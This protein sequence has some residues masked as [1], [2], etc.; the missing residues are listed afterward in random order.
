MEQKVEKLYQSIKAINSAAPEKLFDIVVEEASKILDVEL[1]SLLLFD[2]DKKHLRIKSAKGL[3]QTIIKNTVI[4]KGDGIVGKVAETGEPLLIENIQDY[5]AFA[6]K[7][8][9]T[10]YKTQSLL[11]VPIKLKNEII[12][13]L[14]VNNKVA[15]ESFNKK[16]LH[17]LSIF[18]S[19]ISH[20][21]ISKPK[22]SSD[23]RLFSR[24]AST[25]ETP[26]F[27]A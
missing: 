11:T 22:F 24:K 3:Y 16:D 10:K 26:E 25:S 1:C 27:L 4:N 7:E 17:I 8:L 19:Q 20:Y 12:G 21:L 15:G 6:K 13:V 23:T 2:K 14:N 9:E 5:P 18:A